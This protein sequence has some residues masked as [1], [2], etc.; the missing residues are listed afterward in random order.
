[1]SIENLSHTIVAK[2]DQLNADDLVGGP[3]QCVVQ[4]VIA[5]G[6]ADQPIAIHIGNG[7]QPWKP[8]KTMRRVLIMAWGN[9]GRAWIG[10]SLVL[11]NDPNVSWA[12][13]KVGGIRIAEMSHI[14]QD[15]LVMLQEKK[16]KKA[17]IS[18]KKLNVLITETQSWPDEKFQKAL[19]K[20]QAEIS[21]GASHADIIARMKKVAPLSPEQESIILNIQQQ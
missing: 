6:N 19:A 3:M 8:C 15:I 11:Y 16:G 4:N 2:S 20:A 7:Y 1:M 5:T 14:P 18:I 9:D 12:G 21:Q 13:V 17:P 10:R